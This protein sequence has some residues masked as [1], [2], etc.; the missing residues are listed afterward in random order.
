M[1][2]KAIQ[3][4]HLITE[5]VANQSLRLLGKQKLC[6]RVVIVFDI[7]H[8]DY[9]AELGHLPEHN[10]LPVVVVTFGRKGVT[11]RAA[12]LGLQ[13][14]VNRDIAHAQNDNGDNITPP[15]VVKY[16]EGTAPI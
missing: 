12:E 15:F 6:L 7:C 8:D 1:A 13:A 16:T 3:E 14:R 10:N 9:R 11:A 4:A 5:Q 2:L